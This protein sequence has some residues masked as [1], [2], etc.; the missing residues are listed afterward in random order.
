M[1][2][3]IE[4]L[5][6]EAKEL[7]LTF[8]P[9]IGADRLAQK[10]EE[11]KQG[12]EEPEVEYEEVQAEEKPEQSY[13]AKMLAAAGT[14]DSTPKTEKTGDKM[15]L[16]QLAKLREREARKLYK[17]TVID[18]DNRINNQTTTTTVNCSNNYFD[19]GTVVIPLNTPVMVAKGHI[20]VLK[21]TEII[22]HMKDPKDPLLSITVS[23]PRFTIQ[24]ED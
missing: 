10:I 7:G 12:L 16:R 2:D 5:K 1:S 21:A 18:N 13:A 17:I 4:D 14:S 3:V 15:T 9:N 19:L 24:R 11:Y 6:A 22:Q 8:H 23:R 20:D